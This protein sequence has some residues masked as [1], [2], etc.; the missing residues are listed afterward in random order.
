MTDAKRSFPV[1]HDINGCTVAEEC[2]NESCLLWQ[3]ARGINNSEHYF[4]P[5]LKIRSWFNK[6]Y[7]YCEDEL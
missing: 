1:M 6:I 2:R 7:V 5:E 4:I 3:K